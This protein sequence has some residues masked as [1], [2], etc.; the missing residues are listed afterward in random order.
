MQKKRA[1]TI[2]GVLEKSL[3]DEMNEPLV[4]L[5]NDDIPPAS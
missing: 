1:S 2:A 4:I 5:F 3:I